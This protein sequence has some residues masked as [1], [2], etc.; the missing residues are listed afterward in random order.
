MRRLG[1]DPFWA[2][3]VKD[4]T[5]IVHH[6]DDLK[7]VLGGAPEPFAADP[8]SKRKG[9]AAFQPD[10]LTISRGDLWRNR[11][12]FAE[13]VLDT[14]APLHRLAPV[15]LGLA[16]D[17]AARLAQRGTVRWSDVNSAFQRLDPAGR[18]RRG[19]ILLRVLLILLR[20]AL[21]DLAMPIS[22]A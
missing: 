17:E 15:L 19:R 4:Q 2:R 3:V 14:G 18:V 8:E 12:R 6:P 10:A 20:C 11:R 1:P 13:A 7:L 22:F 16:G 9:M 21:I 5:L